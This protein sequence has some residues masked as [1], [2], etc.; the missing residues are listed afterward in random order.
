MNSLISGSF[1]LPHMTE[2]ISVPSSGM[3][4]A[5]ITV[6]LV[7]AFIYAVII[8]KVRQSNFLSRFLI[9]ACI[10]IFG[11]IILSL[12]D[13]LPKSQKS[14]VDELIFEDDNKPEALVNDIDDCTFAIE[15]ILENIPI[16]DMLMVNDAAQ[17][18]E[19]IFKA[20]IGDYH[21]LYPFLIKMLKD[22]DSEVVHYVSTAIS[23]YRQKINENYKISKEKYQKEPYNS[24]NH[25]QYIDDLLELLCWEELNG[26][27]VSEIRKTLGNEFE[28]LFDSAEIIEERYYIQKY[29]NEI[30][31]DEFQK[32]IET[33]I[34]YLSEFSESKSCILARLEFWYSLKDSNMFNLTLETLNELAGSTEEDD[35]ISFWRQR[36]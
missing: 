10:P 21:I 18:R 5:I 31:L 22:Q 1:T 3:T 2:A 29:R 13:I 12:A 7:V 9:I 15:S 23:G 35:R 25:L 16:D 24:A 17:R 30:A 28:L 20:V 6:N 27:D 26:A 33:F 14:Y 34:G 8:K 36:I 32:A 19:M 4:L 11:L